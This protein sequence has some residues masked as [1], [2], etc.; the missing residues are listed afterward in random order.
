MRDPN[1]IPVMLEMLENIWE[2]NPD[3]RFGQLINLLYPVYEAEIPLYGIS[4]EVL[5]KEIKTY[6]QQLEVSSKNK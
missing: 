6:I 5:L 2:R 4:D 3:M 1:R